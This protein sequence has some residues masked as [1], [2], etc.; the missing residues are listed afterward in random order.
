[1]LVAEGMAKEAKKVVVRLLPPEITEEELVATISKA[2]I[3][4]VNWRS[5]HAGKRYKGEAKPS[6]NSRC[7][8]QFRT[9]SIAE[10]FTKE[11]HGH[12]FIDG[13]GESFRA[14][15]CFAPY[16]KIPRQ[17]PQKD[18]RDGTIADDP[19]YKEFLETLGG[20]KP[21]YEAPPDP[22]L[23]LKPLD[24]GDTPLLNFMKKRSTDR[25]ARAEKRKQRW[26]G[27]G[28]EQ[29]DEEPKKS[30]WRCKECGTSKNLEE[31]PDSRG[32]F[33]CT[34][35]WDYW[36]VHATMPKTK[37]KKSK[38]YK[39][40]AE[41][42][43]APSKSKKKKKKEEDEAYGEDWRGSDR[44]GGGE[45][46][47]E[48]ESDSRRKK[49]KD[50]ERGD[51]EAAAV[52]E[53]GGKSKWRAKNAE[54]EEEW[55]TGKYRKPKSDDWWSSG[56]GGSSHGDGWWEEDR[57]Q[58]RK[59]DKS[60]QGGDSGSKWKAKSSGASAASD[61]GTGSEEKSRRPRKEKKADT[62][63]AKA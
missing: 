45:W 8:L 40:E 62:W 19:A 54:G 13:H 39:D 49:K 25:R 20:A 16:Q 43:E 1:L 21:V 6:I 28:M 56:Y 59:A 11:Y 60:D 55:D 29:I 46:G 4:D 31:D 3:Q 33:Y 24:Y 14:V 34:Y 47:A 27:R 36:E 26:E 10:D 30:K 2:H 9:P 48:E 53:A 12:Q 41:Y 61:T 63:W 17:K 15:A 32:T 44:R 42:D 18:P 5:F 50:R 23:S 57:S 37:K 38:K 58:R 51:K 22:K 7:Y 52:E 35:C